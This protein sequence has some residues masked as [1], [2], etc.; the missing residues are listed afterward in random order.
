MRAVRG[1][2]GAAGWPEPGAT[3]RRS[4]LTRAAAQ[5]T[6]G[7]AGAAVRVAFCAQGGAAP[8]RARN[9]AEAGGLR[10]TPDDERAVVGCGARASTLRGTSFSPVLLVLLSCKIG[11]SETVVNEGATLVPSTGSAA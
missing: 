1:A 2:D 8:S 9:G 10:S 11:W 3:R 4:R 7:A 6:A 5:Y